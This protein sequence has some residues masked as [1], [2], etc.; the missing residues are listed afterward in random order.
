[1]YCWVD[2]EDRPRFESSR[3]PRVTQ[4]HSVALHDPLCIASDGPPCIIMMS[5]HARAKRPKEELRQWFL[6]TISKASGLLFIVT[7][8]SMRKK[9]CRQL[10]SALARNLELVK[11]VKLSP[12]R[13]RYVRITTVDRASSSKLGRQALKRPCLYAGLL[14]HNLR[15]SG[16]KAKK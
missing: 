13:S 5:L 16:A 6:T 4:Y 10:P 8:Y 15:T 11:A 9:R 7:A 12:V 2:A 14:I 3:L 1:V